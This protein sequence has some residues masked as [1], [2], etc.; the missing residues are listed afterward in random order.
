MCGRRE[1]EDTALVGLTCQ[2]GTD[3]WAPG[4]PQAWFACMAMLWYTSPL[5]WFFFKKNVVVDT[6][7]RS[8]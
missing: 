5:Q 1:G 8:K 2:Y 6:R 7:T 4:Q 3:E